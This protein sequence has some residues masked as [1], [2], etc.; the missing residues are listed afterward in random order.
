MSATLP[1]VPGA[2]ASL[3]GPGGAASLGHLFGALV[4]FE[5]V[6]AV[7]HF[8][9][10]RLP[11]PLDRLE[12]W[13]DMNRE[14][15]IATWFAASQLLVTGILLGSLGAFRRDRGRPSPAFFVLAG[16]LFAF[17]SLD[18]A[19]A[20]HERITEFTVRHAW[21]PSFRGG[22]GVWIFVY[23]VLGAVIL[24]LGRRQL[25]AFWHRYRQPAQIMLA[26]AV[27]TV[28]GA[29]GLEIL[30]YYLEDGAVTLIDEIQAAAE[31]LLEM[32]GVSVVLMGVLLLGRRMVRLQPID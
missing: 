10:P 24:A 27:L 25:A 26:G 1:R 28:A 12:I 18:E 7:M 19:V 32:I 6:L 8:V 17:L 15:T 23:A 22:H 20:I 21:V 4:A 5:V 2:W 29:V 11:P 31:E 13:F 16:L 9:G 14:V 3:S 30:Y